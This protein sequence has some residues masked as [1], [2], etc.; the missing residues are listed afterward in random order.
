M[1]I[2]TSGDTA[3]LMT[4]IDGAGSIYPGPGNRILIVEGCEGFLGT[5]HHADVLADGRLANV[6]SLS[7]P[8]DSASAFTW[9]DEQTVIALV[10]DYDAIWG[11]D[12]VGLRNF[13]LDLTKDDFL[14][15]SAVGMFPII[16][17]IESCNSAEESLTISAV[18]EENGGAVTIVN[19]TLSYQDVEIELRTEYVSNGFWWMFAEPDTRAIA[20]APNCLIRSE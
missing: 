16:A 13:E 18:D 7:L 15:I 6:D 10:G 4:E 19:G 11:D 9:V 2:Q 20:S 5:I 12:I 8:I 1:W 14:V 3:E 17:E